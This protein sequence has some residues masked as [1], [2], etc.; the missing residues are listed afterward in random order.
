MT[1]PARLRAIS[2]MIGSMAMF[3]SMDALN[4]TL[5]QGYPIAQIMAIRF[6]VFVA[7][8]CAI[9]KRGP[10]LVFET[11]AP[12][13]QALRTFV[14]LL[15]MAAF[16]VAF[17]YL[18]LAEVHAVAAAAPLLA[19]ALAALFLKER[20]DPI[21][22]G[23]VAGGMF[24]AILV[25]GPAFGDLGPAMWI[26]VAATLLWGVYQVLTRLV[27]RH[28]SA[29]VTT[30]HTPLVGLVL[31]WLAAIPLWTPPDA[32]GWF[33]L[34]AGGT[35]GAFAHI[36]LVRALALAP[37]SDLQPY[38]YFLLVFAVLLGL[39]VYGDVPGLW[40]IAGATL[41]VV[42]GIAAMRRATT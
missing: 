2:L 39:L 15:E 35:M 27:A 42:C 34:I 22:W 3:A 9:A 25:V 17:K 6:V 41:I 14:L 32:L 31:A 10:W 12:W 1:G 5:T 29:D 21:G 37:A 30:L 11:K 19:T 36:F 40:T 7:L 4:K 33:W 20:V 38:N 16:I 23:L 8:A 26:A 18:P 13:L 24:G 28:D